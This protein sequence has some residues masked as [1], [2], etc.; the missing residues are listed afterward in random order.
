MQLL[1]VIEPCNWQHQQQQLVLLVFQKEKPLNN[2]FR[3]VAI[4]LFALRACSVATGADK[5]VKSLESVLNSTG[6]S[7]VNPARSDVIPGGFIVANKKHAS[8]NE[9]PSGV[10]FTTTPF[11]ASVYSSTSSRSFSLAALVNGIA[12]MVGG[13]V[14]VSHSSQLTVKQIDASA[15][16]IDPDVVIANPKV[17]EQLTKWLKDKKA[18]Y[19][20][21]VVDVALSTTNISIT[22]SSDTDIAAAFGATLPTCPS[23][24]DKTSGAAT[25]S[26][27]GSGSGNASSSDKPSGTSKSGTP[28]NGTSTA[29]PSTTAS[30][31][32]TP[33]G[34]LKACMNGN[35]LVGLS[36]TTPLV[37]AASLRSVTLGDD[38]T[39]SV[40]PVSDVA[41]TKAG[42]H[43]T[44]LPSNIDWDPKHAKPGFA[45]SAKQ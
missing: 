25:N 22:S 4:C 11:S 43:I 31:T 21:Y 29:A 2:Y 33:S 40:S 14:S 26:G 41:N 23:A 13:G 18:N 30:N 5:S 9:L 37:F 8:Y 3:V 6:Y 32:S 35:S 28:V 16:K 10:T 38:G 20:V 39:L 7:L 27:S 15:Q 17:Q 19:R 36:T 24:S 42:E 12:K 34:T 44:P 1:I 45:G